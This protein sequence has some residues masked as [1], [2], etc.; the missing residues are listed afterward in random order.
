MK[1]YKKIIT[2]FLIMLIPTCSLASNNDIKI[3]IDG[4]NLLTEISPKI[5]NERTLVPLRSIFESLGA[6]VTWNQNTRTVIGS[7][8]DKNIKLQIGNT[9]ANI[10]GKETILDS[11][12]IIVNDRTLVP[13]RVVAEGLGA[14]VSWNNTTRSVNIKSEGNN[15]VYD[16]KIVFKDKALDGIIREIIEKPTGDILI[17]DIENITE[18]IAPYPLEKLVENIEGIEYMINLETINFWRN[19]ITDI[20]SLKN[21]K[22]LKYLELGDNNVSNISILSNL[23]NLEELGLD[24]NNI[25]DIKP[26]RNLNKLK[27]LRLSYN[28]IKDLSPLKNLRLLEDA[29]SEMIN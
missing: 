19:Y 27:Y 29:F 4:V 23:I 14:K 20:S 1:L 6:K 7:K 10:N 28:N 17:S 15:E 18:L 8:D 21:L 5:V 26:L 16:E 22:N 24:R 3:N 12:A 9:K 2:T 13:I 11:P 25:T